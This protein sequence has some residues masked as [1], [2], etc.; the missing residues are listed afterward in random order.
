MDPDEALQ[1]LLHDA[2]MVVATSTDDLAL[3][4]ADKVNALH[5]WLMAGGFP[6]KAWGAGLRMGE[7]AIRYAQHELMLM[8]AWMIQEHGDGVLVIPYDQLAAVEGCHVR[9]TDDHTNQAIVFSLEVPGQTA[10]RVV[11]D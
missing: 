11:N 7:D 4:M 3:S 8:L 5:E 2:R 6:P 10:L 1:E 9:R